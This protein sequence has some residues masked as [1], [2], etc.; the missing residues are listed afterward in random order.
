MSSILVVGGIFDGIL[1]AIGTGRSICPHCSGPRVTI[2]GWHESDEEFEIVLVSEREYCISTVEERPGEGK[3]DGLEGNWVRSGRGSI[4]SEPNKL[5]NAT[6]W[7]GL[8][9]LPAKLASE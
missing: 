7:S 1:G 4:K 6:V 8:H 2:D 9:M 3:S 5:S